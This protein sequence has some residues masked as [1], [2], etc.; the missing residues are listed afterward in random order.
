MKKKVFKFIR[1]VFFNRIT[2]IFLTVL[3]EVLLFLL[4]LYIVG[5]IVSD[6]YISLVH[7][8]V[9]GVVSLVVM[10]Y[11]VN[12]KANSAYKITW[13][14]VVGL[15][16]YLGTF[17]YLIFGNRTTS[18]KRLRKIRT[19]NGALRASITPNYVY[20]KMAATEE[21][22]RAVSICS[23]IEGHTQLGSYDK[24][25]TTYYP[26]GDDVF[27]VMLEDLKTAKHYIFIEYFII[28]E[29]SLFWGSILE[30]LKEKV[31]EGVEVRVIYDDLG[32]M[33]V[34]SGNYHKKLEKMGIKALCYNKIRP[35]LDVKMNNR[36]HRKIMVIDGHI[37][38]TGGINLCDEYINLYER[39]GHWKDNAIRLEGKAVTSLTRY[40]LLTWCS[41]KGGIQELNSPKYEYD[42][43]TN[44]EDEIKEDYGFVQP[45][46][47]I[48]F[49][50]EALG[51]NVYLKIIDTA[52]KYLYIV[53]P[54]LIIDEEMENSLCLAAKSGVDVR[55]I[56]PHI[57]DKKIVFGVTRSY[58]NKL[59]KAGVK[60]YEYTPGFVH[61]KMFVSD[62]KIATVGTFNLDYRSLYLHSENG[63]FLHDAPCVIDMR[64]DFLKTQL[65]SELITEAK[66]NAMHRK[67]RLGWALLR[68]IAPLM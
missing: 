31:K 42:Y 46:A 18:W 7:T 38:F 3:I 64:D 45:Y 4:A 48:P 15:L 26:L 57:P 8:F 52:K 62:D 14:F 51:E 1:K 44:E 53:T 49:D 39:F 37:G 54:Y 32:S 61:M 2:A 12:S 60:I 43:Y 29:D 50:N 16:S 41:F 40:F 24:T 11:I 56:T 19:V 27:P 30:I 22:E 13:L 67:H 21:G 35:I 63:V 6:E 17:F 66:F 36:D 68:V 47:D 10:I 28:E 9:W 55:I 5:L 59:I 23:Y 25:K 34:T 65:Q 20:K 33:G 58:Y